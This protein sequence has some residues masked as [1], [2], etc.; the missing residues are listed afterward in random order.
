MINR[1]IIFVLFSGCTS[2]EL[3]KDQGSTKDTLVSH[4]SRSSGP[5]DQP[6]TAFPEL[7]HTASFLN[8]NLGSVKAEYDKLKDSLIKAKRLVKTERGVEYQ[9]SLPD[10]NSTNLFD[11][12]S[13]KKKD[14]VKNTSGVL[15][16]TFYKDTLVQLEIIFRNSE[17]PQLYSFLEN[18][19]IDKY[20]GRRSVPTDFFS[21]QKRFDTLSV[22]KSIF[23]SIDNHWQFGD[24]FIVLEMREN[25]KKASAD[26]YVTSA[27]TSLI[28]YSKYLKERHAADLRAKSLDASKEI[29]DDF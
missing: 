4:P 26:K 12:N 22:G 13:E 9:L 1:L 24:T 2:S 28:Y 23:W 17:G 5:S 11:G 3:P 8:L 19:L 10:A 21:K 7:N 16:P 29:Q 27:V 14:K 6:R 20:S 18:T 15:N 25:R